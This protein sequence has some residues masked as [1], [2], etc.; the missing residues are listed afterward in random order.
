MNRAT[1][2]GPETRFFTPEFTDLEAFLVQNATLIPTKTLGLLTE[3]NARL[4]A[5]CKTHDDLLAAYVVATQGNWS[6]QG[7]VEVMA[8][9]Y[10]RATNYM[11]SAESALDELLEHTYLQPIPWLFLS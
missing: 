8:W 9:F 5:I 1:D 3:L 4:G 10:E 7:H 2:M 6:G 11:G